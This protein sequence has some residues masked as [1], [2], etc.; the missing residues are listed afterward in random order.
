M[1]YC[2]RSLIHR[3]TM[4]ILVCFLFVC[5]LPVCG[6]DKP[7]V[8][9]VDS[10]SNSLISGSS[11]PYATQVQMKCPPCDRLHCTIRQMSKLKCPG[12]KVRDVCD[13]CPQCAKL[14]GEK[15]GGVHIYLGKCDRGLVCVPNSSSAKNIGNKS[16]KR[17]NKKNRLPPP[18]DQFPLEGVCRQKR[19]FI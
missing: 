9:N 2:Y 1:S 15:C 4:A 11:Y 3:W 6:S 8:V 12:G 13:C 5:S 16:H 14:E 7:E 17:H 18:D 10:E 19:W